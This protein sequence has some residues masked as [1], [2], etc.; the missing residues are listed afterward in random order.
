MDYYSILNTDLS[1]PENYNTLHCSNSD[2]EFIFEK[3]FKKIK[4][5]GSDKNSFSISD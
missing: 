3:S 4:S 5:N 2:K 1:M